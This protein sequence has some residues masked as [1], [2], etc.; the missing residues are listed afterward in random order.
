MR[1]FHKN[2]DKRPSTKDLLRDPWLQFTPRDQEMMSPKSI[3]F[4]SHLRHISA[5]N[6]GQHA[7]AVSSVPSGNSKMA[8]NRTMNNFARGNG[9]NLSGSVDDPHPHSYQLPSKDKRN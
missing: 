2:P 5:I 3:A 7:V 1:I 4:I 8:L 9:L 6:F